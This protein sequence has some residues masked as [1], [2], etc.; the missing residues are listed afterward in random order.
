MLLDVFSYIQFNENSIA[1]RIGEI[2]DG[3]FIGLE[4][5]LIV[6]VVCLVAL[7]LDDVSMDDQSLIKVVSGRVDCL[8]GYVEGLSTVC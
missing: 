3:L 7:R 2:L 5:P 8:P 4:R 1:G 6:F